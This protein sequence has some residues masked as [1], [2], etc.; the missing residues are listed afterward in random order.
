MLYVSIQSNELGDSLM[1]P[2]LVA[3]YFEVKL[4]MKSNE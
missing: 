4:I 3:F 2:I 1:E